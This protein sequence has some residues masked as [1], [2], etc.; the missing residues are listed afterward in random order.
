[1]SPSNHSSSGINVSSISGSVVFDQKINPIVT[2][3]PPNQE[4]E[5]KSGQSPSSSALMML[6]KLE[7]IIR[8]VIMVFSTIDI[9][10]GVTSFALVVGRVIQAFKYT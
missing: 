8:T 9:I 1:M 7:K 5:L 3:Y 10:L 2:L 4:D 6:I